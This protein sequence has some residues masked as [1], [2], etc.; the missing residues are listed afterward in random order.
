MKK[1]IYRSLP[2][3]IFA[4]MAALLCAALDG[5]LSI[6]MM[7]A[8]D[9]VT[10][11]NRALFNT[12]VVKLLLV[13]LGLIPAT[14]ILSVAKGLYKRKAIV[15]AK[16]SY[17]RGVFD[18]NINEF[19]RDNNSKYVSTLT[20]DVNTIEVNYI[21]GLYEVVVN[22]INFVVGI[23][24]IGYISP[25]ALGVG[26]GISILSTVISIVLSKPIQ[27]HQT[28]RSAL[29]EGYTSYIKEVISA[30][31]IIKSNNLNEKVQKDFYNKSAA[32]Q[33]KGYIIDKLYT[34]ISCLQN[35]NMTIAMYSL[36]G[37]TVFMAIKGQLTLGGV[38]LVVNNMEKIIFPLMQAGEWLPKLFATKQLFVKVDDTLKN[39]DNYQESITI[40]K[41]Q[42][43]IEFQNVSFG[44]QDTEVL[45]D[46][47]LSLKKGEKY[48]VIGPSG[49]GKSTLL[50]LLWKYYMP[51]SGHISIDGSSLRDVTKESYFRHISN[52]EQQVFLF[53]DTVRNNISLYKDYTEEELNRAIEGAGLK[54]FIAGLPE[55][56]DSIITDNG[57]NISGGEKSRIAIARGLLQKADIIFLDEAFASL[58]A[59]V[60]K[61]IETTILSLENITVVNV[62]HVVFDETKRKYDKVFLVK[63]KGVFAV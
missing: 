19:Q 56:L 45:K 61:E 11:M 35:V 28:Q 4:A 29:Y 31:H 23:L 63:N 34:Y 20:N 25:M 57:K 27:T 37:F 16:V 38:I 49:G 44:Y 24:I 55:G 18:K 58:D 2:Y 50:K 54:D 14:I 17:I 51:N 47:S 40:D 39:Q 46:I 1:S 13:A 60:A 3:L 43:S 22:S 59:K 41:L 15:S 5:V 32:I 30:F 42:N 53:E 48:L 21:D 6:Y 52:V 7:K 8:I 26:I 36:V 9:A 62:S 33:H 10:A 12:E